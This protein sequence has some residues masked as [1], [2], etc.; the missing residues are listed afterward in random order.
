MLLRVAVNTPLRRCFDYLAPADHRGSAP[1]PGT[2][3]S[4]PF[5]HRREVAILLETPART[6]APPAKL[7][8]AHAILDATPIIPADMLSLLRWA[9]E[10][11]R[12]PIGEVLAAALPAALRH[13][14]SPAGGRTG[15]RLTAPGR[16]ADPDTIAARAP[17]QARMLTALGR[18]DPTGLA[19]EELRGLGASVRPALRALQAKGLIEACS[20]PSSLPE[21]IRSAEPGPELTAAQREAVAAIRADFGSFMA[22]LLF[23]VTGSGKTEV[24]LEL[25]RE[26]LARGLQALVLVPEIG[27][28]P[29]LVRR[30]ERRLATPL[31]LMHSGLGDRERLESWRAA[32]SGQARVVLGTRSAVFAPLP[33]AGLIV[34]DEEHDTSY[35]QQDGFKYSA[36]DLAV[37]RAR[38]ERIPIVLGSATPSLET[39]HNVYRG[40]YRRLDLPERAGCANQPRIEIVDL[41]HHAVQEGIS[42]PLVLRIQGHLER[43]GQVLLYLNRRGFAPTLFCSE[44]GWIANCLRCD[45]HLTLHRSSHQLRCHHCGAARPPETACPACGCEVHPVGEGT[46]RIEDALARLFP[47]APALRID[48]DT[49]QRRGQI[50]AKLEAARRGEARIL[51][52]TQMLTKGHDFPEVSLV[53]IL[54]ADQGLFGTDFRSSERLA[55]TILQVAG[56]AGRAERPGEVLVQTLYPEHPLLRKLV[57]EGY[58]PFARAALEERRAT[59][60]PP[61]SHLALLRA[62]APTRQAPLDFLERARGLAP[63]AA[64]GI[65]L[66]GPAPAPMERRAGRFRAQLLIQ[67]AARASLQRLLSDWVGQVALLPEA[68]RVRWSIDVDPVE[69]F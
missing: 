69:L 44:C 68:R 16:A 11:Y 55:Q 66:L 17:L 7:R 4:V 53:G 39:L 61:F 41:R 58:E 47:A 24:Y 13:G 10:Y 30:F 43:G 1:L 45:A 33:E 50:E 29:Q 2:R 6:D 38:R 62:E 20:L 28:T 37:L 27:L 59:S 31:A 49:T 22:F 26:A 67:A 14:A 46:Q 3:I 51:V 15:W 57:T 64:N 36:R 18:C 32:R 52:G 65:A 63:G 9:S 19:G 48:R 42:T 35:K 54:N 25:A 23:G 56:R 5:G 8:R 40:R 34:V 60:W 21:V 12:H